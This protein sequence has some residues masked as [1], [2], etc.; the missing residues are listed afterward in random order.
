MAMAVDFIRRGSNSVKWDLSGEDVLPMWVADMDLPV[1]PNIISAITRRLEHPFFGYGYAPESYFEAFIEWARL[2]QGWDISRSWLLH[3]PS[4]MAALRLAVERFSEPGQGIIIPSPVYYPFFSAARDKGRRIVEAPLR[5]ETGQRLHTFDFDALEHLLSEADNRILLLCN[6]HN[7]LGRVWSRDELRQLAELCV[8][9]DVLIIS[10]EIHADIIYPEASFTALLPLMIQAG[11]P[12]LALAIQ[13]P[14]KTFNIPGLLS[15]QLIIPDQGIRSEMERGLAAAG[16]ELPN[17][18]AL[19]AAEAAYRGSAQWL[20]ATLKLLESNRNHLKDFIF[21]NL[22]SDCESPLPQG[23]YL[24][25]LDLRDAQRRRGV[26][27]QAAFRQIKHEAGLWLSPGYMFS[28]S[29]DGFY[30][31]NFACPRELLDEGIQRL[32]TWMR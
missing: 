26:T 8:R 27:G 29:A 17:V 5:F 11:R 13:A 7:P 23:T 4:V 1:A 18:L 30:R 2:R 10:D 31:L 20:D 22:G 32:S 25:W 24:Y 16:L 19:E 15:S 28:E 6:P 3:S 12:D 9:Y 14:S 21:G